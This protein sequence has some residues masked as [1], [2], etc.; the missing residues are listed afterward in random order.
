[1]TF[2]RIRVAKEQAPFRPFTLFLSDQGQFQITHPAFLWLVPGGRT[3]ALA[4]DDG[5]VEILDLVH[6][7]SLK[8]GDNGDDG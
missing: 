8:S 6:I 5:A 3:V 1:M 4:H 7:T 2:D